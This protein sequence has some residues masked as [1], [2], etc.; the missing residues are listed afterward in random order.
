MILYLEFHAGQRRGGELY[1]A[2]LH[3]WFKDRFRAVAPDL[4]PPHADLGRS[5]LRQARH[6]LLRTKQYRPRVLVS[7]ISSAV[8]NRAAVRWAVRHGGKLLLV[9]QAEPRA[10][11][12]SGLRKLILRR[13]EDYLLR[14]AAIVIVNSRFIVETVRQKC[15]SS[16]SVVV[17]PPGLDVEP[18]PSGATG[19]SHADTPVKLLYVGEIS[20]VKGLTYLIEAMS[21]IRHLPVELDV[22]GGCKQEPAYYQLVRRGIDQHGLADRVRFHG[23]LGRSQLDDLLPRTHILVAPSL[24]E[25]YGMMLAEAMCYGLPI[26]ATN[27]GAIPEIVVDGANGLLVPPADAAALAAAIERLVS[28]PALRERMGETNR[29]KALALPTWDDFRA[30]LEC[31]LAPLIEPFL[32]D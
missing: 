8:R 12:K 19:R 15:S 6:C 16:C 11:F 22:V 32:R 20:R 30:T 21:R 3:A 24:S 9:I 2:Q 18:A 4:L 31:D 1:H 13:C 28:G 29:R 17:A 23:H 26:I 27:A 10:K 14:N 5:R 25:G 7:D